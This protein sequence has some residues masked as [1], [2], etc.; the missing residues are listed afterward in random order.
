MSFDPHTFS[1]NAAVDIFGGVASV[2]LSARAQAQA[3]ADS[4]ATADTMAAWE[5][6]ADIHENVI[7]QLLAER[8]ELQAMIRSQAEDVALLTAERDAALAYAAD[9]RR[10]LEDAAD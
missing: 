7:R 3:Q 4:D 2:V 9:I 8:E 10:H 5:E 6:Q 1:R